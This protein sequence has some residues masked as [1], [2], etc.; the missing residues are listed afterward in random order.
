M[1]IALLSDIHFDLAPANRSAPLAAAIAAELK[2]AGTDVV[3]VAGDVANRADKVGRH[4]ARIAVG[5]RANIYVPGNHD[6]WRSQAEQRAGH[7]SFGA[8]ALL[9]RQCVEAGFRYLP[10][11]PFTVNDGS[12]TWGFVGS[13]GWY[14]YSFAAE[15]L[16]LTPADIA[17][18]SVGGIAWIDREAVRFLD[19]RDGHQFSDFEVTSIFLRDLEADLWSI[20]L[21]AHGD[22]PPTVAVTHVLPYASLVEYRGAVDWDYFSSYFGSARF[23]ALYDRYPAVRAVFAGHTHVP[24]LERRPDGRIR[25]IAPI[26]YYGTHEFPYDLGTRIA[27]FDTVG[28]NLVPAER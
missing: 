16:H 7:D 13:L 17:R 18:K 6:V 26:G 24:R 1:R 9:E 5:R 10:R 22:G 25:A 15:W 20:G 19:H 8:L 28:R 2:G 23:G 3:I 4:L 27:F 11:H 21:D 12:N 14:D